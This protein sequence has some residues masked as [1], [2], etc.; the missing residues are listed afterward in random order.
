MNNRHAIGRAPQSVRPGLLYSE[1]SGSGSTPEA[2][3]LPARDLLSGTLCV[4]PAGV[5]A[6]AG[7]LNTTEQHTTKLKKMD[8]KKK[9]YGTASELAWTYAGCSSTVYDW[10]DN[11]C[12]YI[13]TGNGGGETA[14]GQ[15]FGLEKVKRS[16]GKHVKA[17]I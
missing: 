6:G 8:D 17:G 1:S 16:N 9:K 5:V 2:W 12:P 14:S 15:R 11:G 10:E 13:Q 4:S 3:V 7:S